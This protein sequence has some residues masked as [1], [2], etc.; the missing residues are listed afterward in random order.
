MNTTVQ[1]VNVSINSEILRRAADLSDEIAAKQNE[2]NQL[3]A[4]QT[5][6][7]VQ[8]KT[9]II[10]TARGN[11]RFTPEARASIAAAQKRRWANFRKAKK[12]AAAAPV[13]VAPAPAA[14]PTA[15]EA[16]KL[17][18]PAAKAA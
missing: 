18:V 12:N 14:P 10:H 7:E 5:V 8:G 15:A 3:L 17:A 11:R 4:G 2:L 6:P 13:V 9:R 1:A 16:P